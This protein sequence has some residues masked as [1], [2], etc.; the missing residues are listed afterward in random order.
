[1][2]TMELPPRVLY[3][4]RFHASPSQ[5]TKAAPPDLRDKLATLVDRNEKVKIAYR[6][7]QAQIA[8]GLAE[9]GEVFESLAIP[10][11]KLVGLK[12]SEMESEGR[13]STFIFNTERH[14]MDD[15]FENGVR[16][17]DLNNQIR[18]SK[19]EN[20][21]AKLESARKEIVRNHKGQL[22]Q[23]VHMLKHIETQVNSH[24]EDIVQM[25]DDGRNSFQEFIQK[26]LYYLNSVHSQ[27]GDTFP[28]TV[29]LLRV[30]FN[31]IKELLGSVDTGVGDLMQA[32]AKNM[33]NPMSK[34]VGNLAAEVKL[35]PCVQLI[36]VVNEMERAN[37]DTRRELEDARERIRLAEET[38]MEALS[39]LKKVED[40]VQRMASSARF[41]LPASQK[42]QPEHSVNGK[43]ICSE[44][45]RESEEK[46]L[47]NLLSKRRK[48]QEPESPMGPKELIRQAGTKHKPLVYSRRMTRSQTKLS[49]PTG[50]PDALI[51]LGVSPSVRTVNWRSND[52]KRLALITWF[53]P[54]EKTMKDMGQKKKNCLK[55][56]GVGCSRITT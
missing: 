30:L 46:L 16:S 44:G 48:L 37:A 34:Y 54:C 15:T 29:K 35:G 33:C 39:R 24:R 23:L 49:S 52:P 32:L 1:M 28:A 53:R 9:A 12:T 19:E 51:P 36:N 6:R 22:R 17:D 43:R 20:Y 55:H 18:R 25:L 21:A 50:C 4:R 5:Y 47:W 27:N 2:P 56:W 13:L 11:T 3:P 14:H 26:S 31:N 8:S 45:S 40:Q 7:L 42:K 41:L 10:L 38:K